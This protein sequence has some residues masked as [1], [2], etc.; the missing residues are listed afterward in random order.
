[1]NDDDEVFFL[2]ISISL[3]DDEVNFKRAS[4]V[5]AGSGRWVDVSAE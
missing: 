1:M 3:D 5:N 4:E 2:V